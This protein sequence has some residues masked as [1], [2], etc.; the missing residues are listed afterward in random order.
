MINKDDVIVALITG[1]GPRTQE[2]L[3]YI[4][5]PVAVKPTIESFEEATK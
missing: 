2:L 5:M 3:D 4:V 1:A